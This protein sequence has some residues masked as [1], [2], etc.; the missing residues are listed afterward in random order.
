MSCN[1][2]NW[3]QIHSKT[4]IE[5]SWNNFEWWI[6]CK[7]FIKHLLLCLKIMVTRKKSQSDLVRLIP[8]HRNDNWYRNKLLACLLGIFSEDNALGWFGWKFRVIPSLHIFCRW[9]HCAM[10]LDKQ[11]CSMRWFQNERDI[12]LKYLGKLVWRWVLDV[13]SLWNLYWMVSWD[14]HIWWCNELV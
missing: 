7:I 10:R 5:S 3:K 8:Y 12:F 2:K 14:V 9:W 13:N 11:I 4:F 6:Q 1:M